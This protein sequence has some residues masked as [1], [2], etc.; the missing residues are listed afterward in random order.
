MLWGGTEIIRR[1][2]RRRPVCLEPREQKGKECKTR[3]RV[4]REQAVQDEVGRMGDGSFSSSWIRSAPKLD[5]LGHPKL[6]P[7]G[8]LPFLWDGH[9]EGSSPDLARLFQIHLPLCM[10]K[11]SCSRMFYLCHQSVPLMSFPRPYVFCLVW[12]LQNYIFLSGPCSHTEHCSRLNCHHRSSWLTEW[13]VLCWALSIRSSVSAPT[14]WVR[15]CYYRYFSDKETDLQGLNDWPRVPPANCQS[16]VL[17]PG[18][19]DAQVLA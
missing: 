2:A 16:Q 14:P 6:D 17:H 15:H 5:P 10:H 4:G 3:G 11:A 7:L 13:H 12:D 8:N 1:R 18:L 9:M 19:P